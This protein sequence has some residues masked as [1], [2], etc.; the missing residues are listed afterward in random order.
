MFAE[1]LLSV[2]KWFGGANA[3]GLFH[4]RDVLRA[5]NIQTFT[6]DRRPHYDTNGVFKRPLEPPG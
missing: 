6:V 1:Q 3:R 4:G 2:A 5:F